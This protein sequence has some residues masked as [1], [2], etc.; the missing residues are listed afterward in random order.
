[1]RAGLVLVHDSDDAV[2]GLPYTTKLSDPPPI[3]AV[4]YFTVTVNA[5]VVAAGTVENTN[6]DP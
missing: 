4:L 1:M 3:T 5:V 2:V 6:V